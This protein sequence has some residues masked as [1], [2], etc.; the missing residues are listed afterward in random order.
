MILPTGNSIS[1]LQGN[2]PLVH[3]TARCT[4][5]FRSTHGRE[6]MP[7]TIWLA[8]RPAAAAVTNL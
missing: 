5:D 1:S 8:K 7:V 6:Y 4:V 2:P 3:S